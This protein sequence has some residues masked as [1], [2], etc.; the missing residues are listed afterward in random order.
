VTRAVA[1]SP[2]FP[3]TRRGVLTRFLANRD[4]Y[5]SATMPP[6]AH[7]PEGTNYLA[8]RY[9][10]EVVELEHAAA[11]KSAAFVDATREEL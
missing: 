10:G 11:E 8:L 5:G 6:G 2:V 4:A 7:I 3:L 1:S 9:R